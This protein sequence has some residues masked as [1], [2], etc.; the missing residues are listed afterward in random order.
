M[1]NATGMGGMGGFPLDKLVKE[2]DVVGGFEA[3]PGFIRMLKGITTQE[4]GDMVMAPALR[5][6]F[7]TVRGERRKEVA[8]P[9]PMLLPLILELAAFGVSH[10]NVAGTDMTGGL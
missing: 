7:E 1:S 4:T 10:T 8:I 3:S 9:L 6:T 2:A 5:L